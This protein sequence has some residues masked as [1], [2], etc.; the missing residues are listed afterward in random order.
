MRARTACV[1]GHRI[2]S[3][4]DLPLLTRR[5]EETI[6]SL[7]IQGVVFW[8]CGGA[9]GYDALA[10][11]AVLRLRE[12]YPAVRLI[13][14]L[15]HHGQEARWPERERQEYRRLLAAAD[16][17]VYV[18]ETYYDGVMAAR[19]LRLVEYSSYCVAY[20]MHERSGT[21]QSVRLAR[22]RGLTVINL[23]EKLTG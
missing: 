1:T 7:I 9:R 2:I 16:K 13:M 12:K 11:A 22:E 15:P 10:G 17:V 20:L 23:A 14:V 18:S 4:V 21:S 5:L 3:S 6:E 19:N 8:G